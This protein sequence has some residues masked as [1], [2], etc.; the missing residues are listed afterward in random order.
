MT[1]LKLMT[2]NVERG[3]HTE[4]HILQEHRLKAAQRVVENVNPDI[5]ALTEACY[6]GPNSHQII[7]DYAKLF[8]Y[9]YHHWGGYRVF[10]P[11][12]D[13][14]G[15]N[16]LLSKLPFQG[17]TIKFSH[18]GAV[19]GLFSLEDVSFVI[20]VV[21]PSHSIPDELKIHDLEQ[22]VSTVSSHYIMTGDFNTLHPEDKYDFGLIEREFAGFDKIKVKKMLLEWKNA[23]CISWILSRGLQDAFLPSARQSTVPTPYAYGRPQKGVRMDFIFHS[24][25]ILVG[26]A[27]VVKDADTEIASD[28]YPIVC[29][30]SLKK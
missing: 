14:I 6:G 20:D 9:P 24:Q 22:L 11:K 27:Y 10:G 13:D 12:K 25:D 29:M 4:E 23:K 18:K 30:F 17:E 15:G 8:G 7:V 3:F 26:N 16:C 19:R 21:H 5:L 1:V 28:H 2:Y